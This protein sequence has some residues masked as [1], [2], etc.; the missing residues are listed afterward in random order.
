MSIEINRWK[1]RFGWAFVYATTAVVVSTIIVWILSLSENP[2]TEGRG[3][4]GV[5]VATDVLGLPLA[6]GWLIVN[7]IFGEWRAVHG[8]QIVLVWPLSLAI[9][10]IL[11]FLVW[12]F[13][14][15]K[16]SRELASK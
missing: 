11:I 15:R 4:R 8:G 7:G 5:D 1:R 6:P 3:L 14:H 9:D 16:A 10:S 12:E 2:G 13:L